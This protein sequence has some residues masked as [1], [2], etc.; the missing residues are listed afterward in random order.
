[1]YAVSGLKFVQN[2]RRKIY[3]KSFRPKWRFVKLVPGGLGALED[4]GEPLEVGGEHDGQE[5][6]EGDEPQ[7]VQQR[8]HDAIHTLK[9]GGFLG[10][11]CDYYFRRENGFLKPML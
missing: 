4:D 7:Q 9:M 5:G 1:M 8:S 3:T 11:C 10:Q 2:L 6:Q